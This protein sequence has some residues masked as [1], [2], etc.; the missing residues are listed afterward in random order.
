MHDAHRVLEKVR[1]QQN[2]SICCQGRLV[3]RF[4]G[5]PVELDQAALSAQRRG[6]GTPGQSAPSEF[7]LS[8]THN[9]YYP[10]PEMHEDAATAVVKVLRE[11]GLA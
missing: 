6:A 5:E 10:S 3:S 11:L 4:T 1:Y 7:G 9:S 2:L 8:A